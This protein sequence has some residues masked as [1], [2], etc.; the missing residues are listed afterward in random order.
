MKRN[1]E[2]FVF[3]FWPT[4]VFSTILGLVV[5]NPN[6]L[7]HAP[8]LVFIFTLLTPLGLWFLPRLFSY[9]VTKIT[10]QE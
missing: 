4:F 2:G 7:K 3:V 5:R 10:K 8:V 9:I 6:L 1:G